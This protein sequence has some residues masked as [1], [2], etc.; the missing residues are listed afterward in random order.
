[1]RK[2]SAFYIVLASIIGLTANALPGL[3]QFGAGQQVEALT[4]S[5]EWIRA[6]ILQVDNSQEN[7]YQVEYTGGSWA[8]RKQWVPADRLRLPG[9][10]A[11]D[12][13]GRYGNQ[14][15]A[16]AVAP[17]GNPY[18]LVPR[19]SV[20]TQYEFVANPQMFGGTRLP[21]VGANAP[22][23]TRP[24]QVGD[25]APGGLAPQQAMPIAAAPAGKV[26]QQGGAYTLEQTGTFIPNPNLP[27]SMGVPTQLPPGTYASPPVPPGTVFGNNNIP[28]D[29]RPKS[30]T[31]PK[32]FS[33]LFGLYP[34][35]VV[36]TWVMQTGGQFTMTLEG[37]DRNNMQKYEYGNAEG[38][39]V[40]RVNPDGSWTWKYNGKTQTGRWADAPD[41]VHFFGLDGE[42]Q[43][44]YWNNKG[45][46]RLEGKSGILKTGIRA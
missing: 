41:T 5:L 34:Q 25:T 1:M 21:Q 45:Q 43:F 3:A 23:V 26:P 11:P 12:A 36:G 14:N 6:K 20:G 19:G 38:A 46:L 28:P 24:P 10:K 4:F 8:G 29:T 13:G 15:D 39:G 35:N 9:G 16:A 42:E 33:T 31:P 2:P 30:S 32:G 17:A 37:P 7:P 44:A 18:K 22:D 40:L 27:P